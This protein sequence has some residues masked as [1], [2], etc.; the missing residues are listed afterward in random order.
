MSEASPVI[1]AN[2][3]FGVAKVGSVGLPMPNTKVA[4]VSLDTDENGKYRFLGVGRRRRTGPGRP[5]G[6]EGY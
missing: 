6:D 5:A 3:I 2:P 4:I 1:T